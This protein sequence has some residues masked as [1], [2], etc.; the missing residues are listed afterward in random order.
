[1]ILGGGS[2]VARYFAPNIFMFYILYCSRQSGVC[3][4]N[5]WYKLILRESCSHHLCS[6]AFTPVDGFML[7]IGIPGSCNVPQGSCNLDINFPELFMDGSHVASTM[8]INNVM[9]ALSFYLILEGLWTRFCCI[10]II[11]WCFTMLGVT[12]GPGGYFLNF[13]RFGVQV[14]T[15]IMTTLQIYMHL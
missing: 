4:V 11:I 3:P 5:T 7:V 15:Q 8:Q 1:M 13:T 10:L 9:G 6:R 14:D 12:I 2:L